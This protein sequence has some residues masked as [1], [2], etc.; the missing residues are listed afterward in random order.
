MGLRSF[1]KPQKQN[2]SR[3]N[4]G[5]LT[6]TSSL[7]CIMLFVLAPRFTAGASFYLYETAFSISSPIVASFFMKGAV[8]PS[9]FR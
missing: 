3:E 6:R 8:M 5:D 1:F 9:A 4:E 7:L 2:K